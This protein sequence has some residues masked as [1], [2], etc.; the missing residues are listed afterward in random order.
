MFHFF[1]RK[2]HKFV[3]FQHTFHH[4]INLRVAAV[5]AVGRLGVEEG[6]QIGVNNMIESESSSQSESSR[7]ARSQS[8]SSSSTSSIPNE[9]GQ[10]SRRASQVSEFRDV[11]GSD[12]DLVV[13]QKLNLEKFDE[14]YKAMDKE[15]MWILES[16]GRKFE[17]VLY[18]FGSTLKC[19]HL[20]HSFILDPWDSTYEAVSVFTIDE[21]NEVKYYNKQEMPS[22]NN[23]TLAYLNLYKET[24]SSGQV[25]E[26]ILSKQPWDDQ[27]NRDESHDLD[28]IRHYYYTI[29]L[30]C[31][32]LDGDG[33]SETW[34][35][36]HVWTIVDHVFD[37]LPLSVVRG[38]SAIL[39]S[40]ARKNKGRIPQGEEK[41]E[42]K[43]MGH[44]MDLILR[45]KLELGPDEAGKR[46]NDND[47]KLFRERDIKLP[48]ALKDMVMCFKTEA[49]V[50]GVQGLEVVGLL[51]YGLK[52]SSIIMDV[53]V[54]YVHRVTRTK[55]VAV[56]SEWNNLP[57]FRK[58]LFMALSIK[59]IVSRTME[60]LQSKLGNDNDD[61]GKMMEPPEVDSYQLP[62]TFDSQ[63]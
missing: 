27:F 11:N 31:G 35:L 7:V 41:L 46:T 16:T 23:D 42:R 36:A 32:G 39:A 60:L 12:I 2:L 57:D 63:E 21:L 17:E 1:V 26:V 5:G 49:G 47:S 3:E 62:Q 14:E 10:D 44:R 40:S 43:K 28:W 53:P 15:L 45:K 34:L 38:E 52:M 22:V 9:R 56:P 8:E 48:K 25:R 24:K 13:Y 50:D 4:G 61:L 58:V 18:M 55:N 29:E 51:Q 37:N 19:E 54:N 59:E 6:Q 30:E 20:C 33:K